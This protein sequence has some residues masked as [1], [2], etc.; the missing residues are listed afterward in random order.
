MLAPFASDHEAV[1]RTTGTEES[2]Q[3][4]MVYRA[5]IVLGAF[6]LG[7]GTCALVFALRHRPKDVTVY[8]VRTFENGEP[9]PIGMAVYRID[10]KRQDVMWWRHGIA[11]SPERLSH[12]AIRD[13]ENWRCETDVTGEASVV[14][15]QAGQFEATVLAMRMK[16][17]GVSREEWETA[18]ARKH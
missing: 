12:C 6:L 16:D 8:P 4:P 2:M 11:E 9:L 3:K 17:K 18:R 7:C 5:V 10:V 13:V 15:M 1:R 14:T